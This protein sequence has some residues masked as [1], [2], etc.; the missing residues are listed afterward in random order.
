MP[1]LSRSELKQMLDQQQDFM[2]LNVLSISSFQKSHIPGS[3]NVPVSDSDFVKQVESL[4]EGKDKNYPI[5]TYCGGF[6]CD[7]SKNAANLL[8]ESGHVNVSVFEGGM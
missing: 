5:V 4:L 2:L 6:K 1:L 7:A 3:Q 8:L